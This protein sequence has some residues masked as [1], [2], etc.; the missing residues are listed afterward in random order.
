MCNLTEI[1]VSDIT[2][3]EDLNSRVASATLIG[4]LQASYTDFHYLR[5]AWRINCEKDALLGVSMTGI[6]SMELFKYNIKEAASV[7]MS[8]NELV[9]SRIGINKAARV[10]TIKPAGTTSLVLGTSSG[11][12]AWHDNYYWRRMRINKNE[13]I[14]KYLLDTNPTLIEDDYFNPTTT[15]IIKV[16]Q[17]APEGSV[18]RDESAID[19]LNRVRVM[20]K[21]WINPGFRSGY[22]QHNVSCTV[23]IKPDEWDEVRDWMWNNRAIYSG[24][25][26]LPYD[27][28]GYKQAP[29]ESC[30]KEEYN[31]AVVNLK[32]VDLTKVVEGY[33]ETSLMGEVACGGNGCEVT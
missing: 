9:A 27:D 6:A 32:N 1:N 29:F 17:M 3:Q 24:I 10:L 16:P 31:A 8:V 4:T 19:L 30:T 14:Y 11:I 26:V 7:A 21:E 23:S 25:A 13:S 20:S 2:S 15:A 12:H 18:L 33:D 28:H 22:N 5:D